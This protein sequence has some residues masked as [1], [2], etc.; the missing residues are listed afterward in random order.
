MLIIVFGEFCR[1]HL[2]VNNCGLKSILDDVPVQTLYRT[3]L[4]CSEHFAPSQFMNPEMRN[5]LIWNA[6]P[7]IF[8]HHMPVKQ[9]LDQ[10]TRKMAVIFPK[11]LCLPRIWTS[12]AFGLNHYVNGHTNL[13]QMQ[14]VNNG[15]D[16]VQIVNTVK[17]VHAVNS[18]MNPFQ[19]VR[20]IESPLQIADSVPDRTQ[21]ISDPVQSLEKRSARVQTVSS[22]S[23]T[24]HLTCDD[25]SDNH[26][27]DSLLEANGTG[28]LLVLI[29]Q[30][31]TLYVQHYD[32]HGGLYTKNVA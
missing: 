29:S 13:N 2:W 23:F 20:T 18:N 26:S 4:L 7:T 11:T 16:P 1:S 21:P 31:C 3:R 12:A 25:V 10:T 24:L 15:M 6:I 27:E 28:K 32:G 17:P 5:K 14:V 19:V 30:S 9:E 22:P 8:N